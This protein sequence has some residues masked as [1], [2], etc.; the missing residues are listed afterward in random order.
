MQRKVSLE[1]KHSIVEYV[2]DKIGKVK[3]GP[4]KGRRGIA[5]HN[6]GGGG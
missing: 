4:P 2:E 6:E 1:I 5:G 3:V